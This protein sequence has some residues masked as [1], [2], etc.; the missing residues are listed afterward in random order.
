MDSR[1]NPHELPPLPSHRLLSLLLPH[2]GRNQRQSPHVPHCS[3]AKYGA[4]R[5]P[6][7]RQCRRIL[8]CPASRY[9]PCQNLLNRRTLRFLPVKT[10]IPIDSKVYF[11]KSTLPGNS[12]KGQWETLEQARERA[13]WFVQ[14]WGESGVKATA[15][16]FYRDGSIV[17]HFPSEQPKPD[18]NP[19][20]FEHDDRGDN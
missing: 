14:S 19:N 13:M 5:Q 7:G 1:N 20:R 16:V 17:E 4:V 3:P 10:Q 15:A 12:W 11:A 6:V 9:I 8:C 18:A 2:L